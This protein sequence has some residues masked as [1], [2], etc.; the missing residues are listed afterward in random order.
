MFILAG[1][2]QLIVVMVFVSCIALVFI[3]VMMFFKSKRTKSSRANC[4]DSA[5][6]TDDTHR[7]SNDSYPAQMDLPPNYDSISREHPIFV[8]DSQSLHNYSTDRLPSYEEATK[9]LDK[10][11]AITVS[12][13]SY[14][15]VKTEIQNG[16]SEQTLPNHSLCSVSTV[17]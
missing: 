10:F 17:S 7:L 3:S 13:P 12:P 14:D 16:V 5:P 9:Y 15:T 1:R 6:T 4:V 2:W 11:N 8:I